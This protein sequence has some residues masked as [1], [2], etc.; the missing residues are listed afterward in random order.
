MEV[1]SALG[2]TARGYKL[3]HKKG[4][5]FFRAQ[6]LLNHRG[7]AHGFTSREGGVSEPPFNGLN[8]GWSR[9]E[10]VDNIRENYLR[11]CAAADLEYEC[12]TLVSYEHGVTVL[13]VDVRD[14]G[15]GLDEAPLPACDAIVTD[16]PRVTLVTS[17]ADCTGLFFFDPVRRAIGLAHAGWRGT[18]GRIGGRTVDMLRSS[19]GSDPKDVIAAVGPCICRNCYEVDGALGKRFLEEFPGA[20]IADAVADGKFMLDLEMACAVQLLDAG[21]KPENITLMNACTFELSDLLFSHR[22]D[23][24]QTGAM[25]AYIKLL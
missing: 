9:E 24:G 10:P 19:F 11:L 21:L 2:R 6:S 4:V 22:R 5:G 14:R 1:K 13:R 12:L 17:H 3:E 20:P 8:L 25:A 18:L 23:H 7:V 15:R 16:D